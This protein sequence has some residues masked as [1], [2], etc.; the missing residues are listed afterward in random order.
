ML[1]LNL[2]PSDF[3]PHV[4]C[5]HK[6]KTKSIYVFKIKRLDGSGEIFVG[7]FH[8]HYVFVDNHLDKRLSLPAGVNMAKRK[9]GSPLLPLT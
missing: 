2:F 9:Y 4:L 1:W 3:L 6:T 7:A 8:D 5:I